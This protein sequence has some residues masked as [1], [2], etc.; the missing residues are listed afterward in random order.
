MA[1]EAA[2]LTLPYLIRGEEDYQKGAQ[3]QDSWQSVGSKGVVTLAAKLMLALLPPNT[4]FFKLQIDDS[5][6]LTE[7]IPPEIR[8][9]MDLS[10][11][12]IERMI[13]EDISASDDRVVIHQALKHLVVAGNALIFMG[14]KGLKMYPLNRYTVDRDGDGNVIEIVTREKVS[15]KIGKKFYP[16]YKPSEPNEVSA[17]GG[18]GGVSNTYGEDECDIYTHCTLEGKKWSWYQE[19]EGKM[20]PGSTS[21]APV[22]TS[23]WL[24]LTMNHVDGEVY[25]RGR[26]EEF[27]GDSEES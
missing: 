25:G 19:I 26:V 10:F 6:M 3:P 15:K 2:D 11:S 27:I 8:S 16:K 5:N 18:L 4:S 17:G 1:R 24:V 23:P 21:T 22:E 12:K 20:I 14:P 7:E 9:E 13:M